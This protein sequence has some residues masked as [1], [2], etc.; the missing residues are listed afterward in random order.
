MN[1]DLV[2]VGATRTSASLLPKANRQSLGL[3]LGG[4][5]PL[6]PPGTSPNLG[7][8]FLL[9]SFTRQ[10]RGGVYELLTHPP[11]RTLDQ[12]NHPLALNQRDTL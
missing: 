8:E 3:R 11:M 6:R 7:E 2:I 10:L 5:R 4:N 9:H 12:R 1:D